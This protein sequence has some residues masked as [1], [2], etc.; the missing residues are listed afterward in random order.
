MTE[1][2]SAGGSYDYQQQLCDMKNVHANSPFMARHTLLVNSS[3]LL[4]LV[5]FI[6]CIIGLY[7]PKKAH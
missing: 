4:A 7:Q 5:G 1:C 3:M 6:V 2:V